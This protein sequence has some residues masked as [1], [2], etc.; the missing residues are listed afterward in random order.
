MK[1]EVEKT[2]LTLNFQHPMAVCVC[3][4]ERLWGTSISKTAYHCD[5]LTLRTT[6][7]IKCCTWYEGPS[8]FNCLSTLL[9]SIS[10][11]TLQYQCQATVWVLPSLHRSPTMAS[12]QC[13][14]PQKTCLMDHTKL[15]VLSE[16][17]IDVSNYNPPPAQNEIL[18]S[19]LLPPHALP[20]H[21]NISG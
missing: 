7:F 6:C 19:L 1:A 17:W 21:L 4:W 11:L 13:Q 12:L 3:V 16:K 14:G 10:N 9:S 2:S 18:V 15:C 20:L 8:F 5:D